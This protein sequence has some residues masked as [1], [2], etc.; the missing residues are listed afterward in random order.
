MALTFSTLRKPANP[1]V[2]D[3]S[4]GRMRE[5]WQLYFDGLTKRLNGA[6]G[7]L[8]SAF[9][10]VTGPASSTDGNLASF[11]GTDGKTIQDS[12]IA[13]A[14][15]LV[16]GDIGSAVQ[17]YSAN[18]DAWSSEDPSDYSATAE[19]DALYQPLDAELTAVAGISANGILAR[20]GTGTAAARTITAGTGIGV[21]NGDGASGDPT[22]AATAATTSAVG[23]VELATDA[24]VYAAAAGDKVLTA[25]H[26]ETAQ[27]GVA[28]TNQTPAT[29]DWEAGVNFTL[30]I[31][32]NTQ[33]ATPSNGIPGQWRTILVQ[34]NSTTDRT[35]TFS[36]DYEGDIPTITDCDSGRWYL[37][38]IYCVSASHFV[39]SSKKANGT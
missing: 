15:V 14:N 13:A 36:G 29:W 21:T 6:V 17:A 25:A 1:Q 39:V 4:T 32:Q 5:E 7:E 16:D 10:D 38:M 8:S 27:A 24:E 30:T 20:T 2:V 9:G 18:L 26:L 31:S 11:D 3:P 12:G 23:A 19:A 33:I 37:L 22:I 28:I 34:G 35:I